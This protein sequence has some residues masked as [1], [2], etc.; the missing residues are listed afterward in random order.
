MNHAAA[1]TARDLEAA[2]LQRCAAVVQGQTAPAADQ[3][4][5]NVFRLAAMLVRPRFPAASAQL[6][7]ASERYFATHP[8]D[9]LEAAELVRRGWVL[10]LPRWRDLLD[11]QLGRG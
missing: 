4:E 11:Q 9:R 1:P 3:R 7:Q 8:G 6:W 2:L 10:G 5:A